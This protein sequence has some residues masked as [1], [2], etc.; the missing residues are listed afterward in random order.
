MS[1]DHHREEALLF[2]SQFFAGGVSKT[3]YSDEKGYT[4]KPCDSESASRSLFSEES[5]FAYSGTETEEDN[6]YI[7]DLTRQMGH[8]MFLDDDTERTN[9]VFKS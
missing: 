9:K 4:H 5:E 3:T 8:Y 1:V 2:H 7:A 6:E